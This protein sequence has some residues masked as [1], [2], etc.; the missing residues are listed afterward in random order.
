[1]PLR[2]DRH[3]TP[4]RAAVTAA[5]VSGQYPEVLG[6]QHGMASRVGHGA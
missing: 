3:G 4:Q 6:E 1:M 2:P 5:V